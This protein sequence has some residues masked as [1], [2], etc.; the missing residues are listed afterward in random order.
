MKKD[1]FWAARRQDRLKVL[2]DPVNHIVA[3]FVGGMSATNREDRF[4]VAQLLVS[5]HRSFVRL[6]KALGDTEKEVVGGL[7]G[8]GSPRVQTL[9]V[10]N[11]AETPTVFGWPF[12]HL[13]P[14]NG[15]S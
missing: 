13:V 11:L 2:L 9:N 15:N 7:N 1:W 10:R 5:I 14:V 6:E 3:E 12:L 4:G 8:N